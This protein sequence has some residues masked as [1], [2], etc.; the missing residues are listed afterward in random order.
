M[1]I[2]AF[3]ILLLYLAVISL[4]SVIVTVADKVRSIKGRWRVPENTLILL[5]SLGGSLAML[6]TMRIIRHKTRHI[7]FMAG[8]P[9]IL[10]FQIILLGYLCYQ[11]VL[12]LPL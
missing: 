11:G 1:P 6:L 5:S 12:V 7:K 10:L 9:I 8:I 2:D 4:V 3:H